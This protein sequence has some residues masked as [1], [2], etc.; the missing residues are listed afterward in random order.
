MAYHQII[1]P[2]Q[3]SLMLFVRN[4][5][6]DLVEKLKD[7]KDLAEQIAILAVEA[8]IV[9]DGLYDVKQLSYVMEQIEKKLR[10]K[11][12]RIIVLH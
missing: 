2:E 1:P 3:L 10:E 4:E 5:C 8:G 6:P 7:K 11:R 9:L 12:R